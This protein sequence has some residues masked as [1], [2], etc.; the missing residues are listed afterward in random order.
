MTI[1]Q[2]I[3]KFDINKVDNI[4]DELACGDAL[5]TQL[6][7]LPSDLEIFNHLQHIQRYEMAVKFLA[8][9]LPKREAIWWAY[10]CSET[11][12]Q[13]SADD[14]TQQALAVSSAWVKAPDEAKRRQAGELGD[15]LGFYTSASWTATAIFWSGGS[16]APEGR[17]EVTPSES[18]CAEA[19]AN[20]VTLGA[21]KMAGEMADAFTL[22]LKRGLHIAMGGNGRIQ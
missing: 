21:Y 18:M 19:I 20:A 17:P 6:R 3:K 10:I 9:G 11:L 15:A 8:M 1:K 16:I 7:T 22:F 12:E 2:Q 5:L 4:L 13:D 14:K